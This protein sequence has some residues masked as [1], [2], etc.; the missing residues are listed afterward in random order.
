MPT[1]VRRRE[2]T[3]V[4]A[5]KIRPAIGPWVVPGDR[6]VKERHLVY[7]LGRPESVFQAIWRGLGSSDNSREPQLELMNV[8][9]T[10]EG[11]ASVEFEVESRDEGI[12]MVKRMR[13]VRGLCV[14]LTSPEGDD[15]YSLQA[16]SA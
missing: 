5:E 12:Q 8:L 15:V 7:L 6:I 2:L 14:L 3:Q 9:K 10:A 13:G 4:V 11:E 1:L 16:D